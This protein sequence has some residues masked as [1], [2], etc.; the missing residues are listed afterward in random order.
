[1]SLMQSEVQMMVTCKPFAALPRGKHNVL[2]DV[3]EFPRVRVWDRGMFTVCHELSTASQ[4][5]IIARARKLAMRCT[6]DGSF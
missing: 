5:S 3:G 4:R 1:M 2:V 6:C